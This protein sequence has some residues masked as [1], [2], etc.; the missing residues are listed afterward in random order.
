MKKIVT[1]ATLT[2]GALAAGGVVVATGA[3]ASGT[4][5]DRVAQCESTNNWS[6]N[7]GN[8]YYGG[9]QFNAATWRSVNG[10]DFASLP[11]QASREQQIT[12]AN[13]LFAIRG[14]Q[15]WACA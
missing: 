6:I 8:G 10:Q 12:V 3:G 7:T 5:W 9:L 13:R 1:G 4:V 14:T 2:V 11:H 15:P